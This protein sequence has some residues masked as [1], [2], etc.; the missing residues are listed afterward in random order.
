MT[1]SELNREKF[2]PTNRGRINIKKLIIDPWSVIHIV[3]LL[4]KCLEE[5]NIKQKKKEKKR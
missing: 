3:V 5:R 4:N 1:R 2:N